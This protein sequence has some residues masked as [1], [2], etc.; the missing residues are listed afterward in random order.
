MTAFNSVF[1]ENRKMRRRIYYYLTDMRQPIALFLL[2]LLCV[3]IADILYPI[4]THWQYDILEGIYYMMYGIILV[5][6]IVQWRYRKKKNVMI[7]LLP[8]ALSFCYFFYVRPLLMYLIG[9]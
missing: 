8:I 7:L 6:L 9:I 2:L 1:V 5:P 3:V 4:R